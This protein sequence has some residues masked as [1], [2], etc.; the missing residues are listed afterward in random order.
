MIFTFC[1]S[2]KDQFDGKIALI[3][4]RQD[5]DAIFD[6]PIEAGKCH[7]LPTGNW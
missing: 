3:Y 7:V 6:S 5:E 2:L 1:L 4:L